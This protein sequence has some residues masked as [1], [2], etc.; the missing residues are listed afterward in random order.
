MEAK[1]IIKLFNDNVEADAEK[2]LS[3]NALFQE[4]IK[5]TMPL[6]QSAIMCGSVQM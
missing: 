6:L 5:I 1:E 2:Q 3:N 4:A